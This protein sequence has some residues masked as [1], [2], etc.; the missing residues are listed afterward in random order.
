[1]KFPR[2]PGARDPRYMQLTMLLGYS[3]AARYIF[4]LERPQFVTALALT[5]AVVL[6]LL[7]GHFYYKKIVFPLSAMII[8][9]ACT[10][11]ISVSRW[12]YYLLAVLLAIASKAFCTYRGRHFL[13]PANFGV[14]LL[15]QLL[16][17]K[18]AA[19]PHL[20]T[21][22]LWPSIVF[23][24][25]GSVTSI[26][27]GQVDISLSWIVGFL[28]FGLV[29]AA[30]TGADPLFVLAPMLS[31]SFL[32]FS[33]HMLSDPA[34]TPRYRRNRIAYAVFV[35]FIDAVLRYYQVISGMLYALVFAATL[36]PWVRDHEQ[37]Q[38]SLWKWSA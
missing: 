21:G 4:H 12:E 38:G 34:T 37:R 32:V 36:L 13:N 9:L 30:L 16:P 18:V 22:Y 35:A 23:A 14:V 7:L 28:I 26:Y 25:L 27:A 31:S 3:I 33:F 2:P 8:A 15:I 5:E 11:L 6:D 10:I 1:M 29:R 17:A 19:I 24:T 20:F